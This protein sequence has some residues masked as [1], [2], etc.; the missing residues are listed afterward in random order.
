MKKPSSITRNTGRCTELKLNDYGGTKSR[1]SVYRGTQTGICHQD[2]RHQ[3]CEHKGL[4][5]V[6]A[7]SPLTDLQW[8]LCEAHQDFS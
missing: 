6:A 2:Q 7:S 1:Q 8:H 3:W 4:K 5:S